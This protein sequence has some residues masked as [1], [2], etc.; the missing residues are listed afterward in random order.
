VFDAQVTDAQN[1]SAVEYAEARKRLFEYLGMDKDDQQ[2]QKSRM[3]PLIFSKYD[4]YYGSHP[5]KIYVDLYV[6][7]IINVVC[8]QHD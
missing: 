2:N 3:W 1:C 6:T 8:V 4:W 5:A 7:S